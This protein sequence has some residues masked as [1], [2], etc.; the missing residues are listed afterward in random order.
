[1]LIGARLLIAASGAASEDC[2]PDR[3]RA[4]AQLTTP[5]RQPVPHERW[6]WALSC[7][8][9][10]WTPITLTRRERVGPVREVGV[11]KPTPEGS[12]CRWFPK[13]SKASISGSSIGAFRCI[14][15]RDGVDGC[16]DE[17]KYHGSEGKEVGFRTQAYFFFS[18][19]R[20]CKGCKLSCLLTAVGLILF[21]PCT[22][23]SLLHY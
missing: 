6:L 3:Q 11:P 9:R 12:G 21:L 1:M 10:C 15:T 2:R 4:T 7:S 13:L 16:E 14:F 20:R 19:E 22:I 18:R 5:K 23:P 8:G 17:S